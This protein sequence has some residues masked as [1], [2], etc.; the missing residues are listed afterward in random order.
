MLYAGDWLRV[1]ENKNVLTVDN[2]DHSCVACQS[3]IV[4]SSLGAIV[5]SSL[6]K[7]IVHQSHARAPGRC[8]RARRRSS[9]PHKITKQR[10]NCRLSVLVDA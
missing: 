4:V 5:V 1:F 7:H 6:V 8:S 2:I 9:L 3:A 10:K